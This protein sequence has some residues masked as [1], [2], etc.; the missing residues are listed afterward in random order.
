MKR[1]PSKKRLNMVVVNARVRNR[2]DREGRS[3]RRSTAQQASLSGDERE[4]EKGLVLA[5]DAQVHQSVSLA[6][7]ER[8]SPG[9]VRPPNPER[10]L[11]PIAVTRQGR[12][13]M[14]LA[15]DPV[16][17]SIFPQ[18]IVINLLISGKLGQEV[19]TRTKE[20]RPSDKPR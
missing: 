11:Q 13:R 7:Q 20:N 12:D 9:P 8:A 14:V 18:G 10:R 1:S 6:N 5:V 3:R 19:T 4:L 16:C 15:P 2:I 17:C